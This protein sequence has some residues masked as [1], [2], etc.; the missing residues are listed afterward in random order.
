[1]ILENWYTVDEKPGVVIIY[2]NKCCAAN[3]FYRN[4]KEKYINSFKTFWSTVKFR[5][6]LTYIHKG[7]FFSHAYLRYVLLSIILWYYNHPC[8]LFINFK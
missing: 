1:M 5:N 2:W 6:S 7:V 3:S 4:D 8:L